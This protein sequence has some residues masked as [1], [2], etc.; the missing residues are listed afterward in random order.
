MPRCFDRRRFL[1]QGGVLAVAGI[2]GCTGD[3]SGDV[4]E[5]GSDTETEPDATDEASNEDDPVSEETQRK[6]PNTIFVAQDGDDT[7]RGT[8]E[9]IVYLL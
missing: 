7:N 3:D 9:A 5:N 6:N 2:A 8:R 4:P 1:R